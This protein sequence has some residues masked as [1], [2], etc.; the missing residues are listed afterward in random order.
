MQPRWEQ[1]EWEQYDQPQSPPS[2][3]EPSLPLAGR[4]DFER[5]WPRGRDHG[6]RSTAPL[7][8]FGGATVQTMG[9]STMP[10]GSGQDTLGPFPYDHS[11]QQPWTAMVVLS[12]GEYCV[13][14]LEFRRHVCIMYSQT[15]V[16]LTYKVR[17]R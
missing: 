6:E 14:D 3:T 11:H 16:C 17:R 8:N 1:Y 9:E 7:G 4:S 2:T 5:V 15:H 13:M 12:E 10:F